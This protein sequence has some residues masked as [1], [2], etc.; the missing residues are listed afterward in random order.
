M[1]YNFDSSLNQYLVYENVTFVFVWMIIVTAFMRFY[2]L[3]DVWK[4]D[5]WY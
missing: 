2:D 1:Q 5:L 4:G 3:F